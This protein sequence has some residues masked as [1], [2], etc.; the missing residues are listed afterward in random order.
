MLWHCKKR[1]DLNLHTSLSFSARSS[2]KYVDDHLTGMSR[3]SCNGCGRGGWLGLSCC[4][5]IR[6]NCLRFTDDRSWKVLMFLMMSLETNDWMAP[7]HKSIGWHLFHCGDPRVPQ[8][9][10]STSGFWGSLLQLL[11]SFL[12]NWLSRCYSL[13]LFAPFLQNALA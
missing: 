4:W 5:I 3:M 1:R 9:C 8:L 6:N 12:I 10:R 13:T 2:I 7:W 11:F